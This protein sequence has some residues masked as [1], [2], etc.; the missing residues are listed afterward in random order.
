MKAEH[1][2]EKTCLRFV[3]TK[4]SQ[5]HSSS[6]ILKTDNFSDGGGG[7]R[8]ESTEMCLRKVKNRGAALLHSKV[9][10][11]VMSLVSPACFDLHL[12]STRQRERHGAGLP[13]G[14]GS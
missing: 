1:I 8:G 14:T 7:W 12:T 6:E 13:S 10:G 4:R 9:S 5:T 11:A 3:S 2:K